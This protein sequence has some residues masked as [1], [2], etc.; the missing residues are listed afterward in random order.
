M[1]TYYTYLIASLPMLHFQAKPPFS[2]EKFL[3]SCEG[4]IPAREIA[5]LKSLEQA[6]IP[7]YK[8]TISSTLD[9]WHDFD[10][11]LRNELVK[12]RA[13]RKKIDPVLYLRPDDGYV[14]PYI[15]HIALH[16]HRNPSVIEGER[17]L[18]QERWN[19][20]EEIGKGHFFDFDFLAVYALKLLILLRWEAIRL[21]DKKN[22]LEQSL[23]AVAATMPKP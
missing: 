17:I 1:A 12:I 8:G 21:A 6:M 4:F 13:S 22:L 7:A 23:R 2:F 3:R 18:D 20:L 9:M 19:K 14:E 5:A 15:T 16:A 10:R 11:D